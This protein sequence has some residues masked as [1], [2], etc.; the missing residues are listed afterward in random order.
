MDGSAMIEE[1][2]KLLF[3]QQMKKYEKQIQLMKDTIQ[4]MAMEFQTIKSQMA[5]VQTMKQQMREQ[6]VIKQQESQRALPSEKPVHPRQGNYKPEDVDIKK[7]FY[8][9][10]K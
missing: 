4:A 5:D 9:G 8:F 3:E 2:Y 6:P 7:M 1:K 10:H